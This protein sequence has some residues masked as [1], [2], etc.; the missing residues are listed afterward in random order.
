MEFKKSKEEY[1][2]EMKE[3]AKDS[4][5]DPERAHEYADELLCEI[6]IIKH[7]FAKILFRIMTRCINKF[8][9]KEVIL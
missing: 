5:A 7:K 2:A 6:L 9:G 1:V 8:I 4:I 3:I